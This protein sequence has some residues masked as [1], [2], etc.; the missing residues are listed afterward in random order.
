MARTNLPTLA[1]IWENV[2]LMEYLEIIAA[3]DLDNRAYP[4]VLCTQVSDITHSW[5]GYKL[6][7]AVE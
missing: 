5:I 7:A 6:S 2:T 1:F 3:C 4:A